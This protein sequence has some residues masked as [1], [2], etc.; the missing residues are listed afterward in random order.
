MK[1][2]H[3]KPQKED[4]I[5]SLN[6]ESQNI[7]NDNSGNTIIVNNKKKY[8]FQDKRRKMAAAHHYSNNIK[9]YNKFQLL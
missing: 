3:N 5:H 6:V 8:Y 2:H 7:T 1:T 9:V 4:T